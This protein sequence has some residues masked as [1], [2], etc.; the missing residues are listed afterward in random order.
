MGRERSD[1]SKSESQRGPRRLHSNSRL[2]TASV[3]KARLEDVRGNELD[4][5]QRPPVQVQF[6]GMREVEPLQ[7]QGDFAGTVHYPPWLGV[8]RCLATAGG[9]S[10]GGAHQGTDHQA[11]AAEGSHVGVRVPPTTEGPPGQALTRPYSECTIT[12]L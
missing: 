4:G 8:T 9:V 10:D 12:V 6:G 1:R 7:R 11:R 3:D 5:A 2:G